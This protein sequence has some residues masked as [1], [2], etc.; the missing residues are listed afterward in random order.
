MTIQD[1]K[2]QVTQGLITAIEELEH[3]PAQWQRPWDLLQTPHNLTTGKP[4]RGINVLLF[5]LAALEAGYT[6][7][8]W[9]T[10]KQ[11]QDIGAQVRKGEKSVQGIFYSQIKKKGADKDED[12][13]Y[14]MAK[15]FRVFNAAQIDGLEELDL[16]ECAKNKAQASELTARL[17]K[18]L[19]VVMVTQ[20]DQPCYL[21]HQDVILMPRVEQFKPNAFA[22]VLFHEL[23][24]WTG[25]R[26]RS[27]RALGARWGQDDGYAMEELV[28]ELFSAHMMAR[29]GLDDG[30]EGLRE[31]RQAH[32]TYLKSWLSVFK[33][34]SQAIFT[35]DA[36]AQRAI[37]FIEERLG[38]SLEACFAP[39]AQEQ[40]LAA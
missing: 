35:A 2:D 23:G 26:G 33:R 10:Y 19:G 25:G 18:P 21:P 39:E 12:S 20:G 36:L 7:G 6:T 16:P 3:N 22:R 1:L 40:E 37:G 29:L 4:Y 38:Q 13:F 30:E 31:H 11:A 27:E 17:L 28:A 5:S 34:D 15:S 9:C 14:P 8:G 32:A 24:H